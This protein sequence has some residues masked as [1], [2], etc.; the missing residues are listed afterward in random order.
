MLQDQIAHQ[1][2]SDIPPTSA[3]ASPNFDK[4]PPNQTHPFTPSPHFTPTYLNAPLHML[5]WCNQ[6]P[7]NP[8]HPGSLSFT[9][10]VPA[11]PLDFSSSWE[12]M[13]KCDFPFA[14]STSPSHRD[15]E[16]SGTTSIS[17]HDTHPPTTTP[18]LSKAQA[19]GIDH[20]LNDTP[21]GELVITSSRVCDQA[22]C[23]MTV[24]HS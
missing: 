12:S 21:P 24:S 11:A 3:P 8:P 17:G 4:P 7:C 13:L 9:P 18:Q 15:L 16:S 6:R 1:H 22:I 10:L 2:R 14:L 23:L 19:F 20:L 5:D